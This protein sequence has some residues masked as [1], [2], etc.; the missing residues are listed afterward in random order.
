[1]KDGQPDSERVR[2]AAKANARLIEMLEDH[3]PIERF[4]L[5]HTNAAQKAE[6]FRASIAEMLPEGEIY[7]M[8]ITPVIG[9]HIG[10]GA[11]GFAIVSGRTN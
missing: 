2:T 6:A 1:M 8:D 9:A 11:V 4:S 7:S 10:P 3:Q 5:L